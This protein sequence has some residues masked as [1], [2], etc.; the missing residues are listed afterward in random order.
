MQIFHGC[1]RGG[2]GGGVGVVAW[3]SMV[4]CGEVGVAGISR[5]NNLYAAL[6]LEI[7]DINKQQFVHMTPSKAARVV[8]A[9][10]AA[11]GA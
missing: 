10:E 1:G 5:Q 2:V 4:W 9:A 8:E 6:Q 11:R 3:F 7:S